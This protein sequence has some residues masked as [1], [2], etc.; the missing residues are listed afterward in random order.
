MGMKV[1]MSFLFFLV[2][3]VTAA[4]DFPPISDAERALTEVPGQPG[5]PAAVLFKKAELRFMDYPSEPSSSLD[6]QVR[7]K[8]LTEEG[9]E[10]GEVEIPHS[11]SYRLK[12]VSGR[13]VLPGGKVVELPEAAIFEEQR[14][15]SLK[16]SVTKLVFP[17]V[18]VGAILDYSYSVKWDSMAFLEPW[19]LQSEVPT[20]LS[21]ITYIKPGSLALKPWGIAPP[22]QPLQSDSRKT[23]KGLAIRIWGED[24]PGVPEEPYG[25]PFEA[26]SSRFMM[27]PTKVS[28]SGQQ[29]YLLE[30][31][32]TTCELYSGEYKDARRKSRRAKQRAAELAGGAKNL[33]ERIAA[34]HAFVRDEIRTDPG[35]G[36]GIA[37]DDKA[38]DVVTGRHGRPIA[39]ALALQAM[40]DGIKVES[41]LIWVADRTSGTVD[42]EV[43][44]P[45]WFDAALVRVEVDGHAI[46]LDPV[47]RSVGFGRL[48]PYYEG[49]RGL[50]FHHGKPEIVDLPSSSYEQNRRRAV[51]DLR[52]DE[53]GRIVG[54]GT[55]E[56]DGHQAWRYLRWKDDDEATQEA[57]RE[58]LTE[59]FAGYDV[60]SVKVEE[61][62]DDQHLRVGWSLRQ[63]EEDLLGDEVT[64]QPAL[65]VGPI[66]Q[67]FTLPAHLRRTPVRLLYGRRDEVVTTLTWPQGWQVDLLPEDSSFSNAAGKIE[68]RLENDEA[69]GK[70]V[71]RRSF[72]ITEREFNNSDAY[73]VLRD[74]YE[75]AAKADAQN[76]VLVRD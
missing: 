68:S 49:T 64:V 38:D 74:L 41:D 4:A 40:L 70:I 11:G 1:T 48:A 31:W 43:P 3:A 12:K 55:L 44:N 76:L 13:T 29:I 67:P 60:D 6:V 24:L 30:S 57:W 7:L 53:N 73:G 18:E 33:L 61:Q 15:R 51:I 62:I 69:T 52:I 45:W 26:L 56:L 28:V 42:F 50:E 16:I 66:T 10:Y 19:Y 21:E 63:R 75:Q 65:P 59:E 23:A 27:V 8:I 37:D 47:D 72:A 9:K 46:Y 14:S 71:F 58:H 5:A 22:N 25:P 35:I 20:R 39:K 17:A 34:I 32:E 54:E 36:V 2:L